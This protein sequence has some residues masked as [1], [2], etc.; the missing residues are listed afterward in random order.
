MQIGT[1]LVGSASGVQ[2]AGDLLI[3]EASLAGGDR[4]GTEIDGSVCVKGAVGG[5]EQARVAVSLGLAG[6]PPGQVGQVEAPSRARLCL[7]QLPLAFQQPGDC[8][9]VQAAAATWPGDDV[10]RLAVDLGGRG[11]DVPAG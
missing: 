5:P 1:V 6:Y 11:D 3:A 9:P 4:Q 10:V 7:V 2:G 8:I